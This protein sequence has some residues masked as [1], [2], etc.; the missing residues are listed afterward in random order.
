MGSPSVTSG[1]RTASARSRRSEAPHACP[2]SEAA[3]ISGCCGSMA[4][5]SFVPSRAT[6]QAALLLRR[7]S[8]SDSCRGLRQSFQECATDRGSRRQARNPTDPRTGRAQERSE[9]S[10]LSHVRTS[11]DQRWPCGSCCSRDLDPRRAAVDRRP[12]TDPGEIAAHESNHPLGRV[13]ERARRAEET[14]AP[15]RRMAAPR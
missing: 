5:S 3:P 9:R 2:R 4:R 13:P 12:S 6:H 14:R 7:S 8:T 1:P 10:S 11:P 15:D